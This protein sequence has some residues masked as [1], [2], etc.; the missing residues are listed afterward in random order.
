MLE[1]FCEEGV[2]GVW[3]LMVDGDG[4]GADVG[5]GV[6]ACS[7]CIEDGEVIGDGGNRDESVEGALSHRVEGVACTCDGE[8][9][10]GGE[11]AADGVQKLWREVGRGHGEL[12]MQEERAEAEGDLYTGR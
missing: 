8:E 1:G 10:W 9:I 4:E 7:E 2:E 5:G 3:L 6:W 12:D 11:E